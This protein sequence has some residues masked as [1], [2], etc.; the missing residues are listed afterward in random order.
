MSKCKKCNGTGYQS[1]AKE[2]GM[3]N[4]PFLQ[5]PLGIWQCDYCNGTGE[6]YNPVEH[7]KNLKQQNPK[8][9]K[10]II[11]GLTNILNCLKKK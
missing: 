8:L 11:D 7:I 2:M 3:E 10:E 1:A 9:H 4:L 5:R 6:E